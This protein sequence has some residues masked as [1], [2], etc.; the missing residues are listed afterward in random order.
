NFDG[1]IYYSPADFTGFVGDA[2]VTTEANPPDTTAGTLR[3]H[4]NPVTHLYETTVFDNTFGTTTN[5][6]ARFVEGDVSTPTPTPTATATGTATFTPT[7][8]ATATFTPTPTATA[9]FTPTPT[10]TGTPGVC[11]LT[12]GYWKN[13]PNAWPV[14]SLM[15]GSQSYTKAELLAILNTPSGG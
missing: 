4:F 3:V 8:T 9:T 14:N 2:I 11:P 6:G 10:P 12:Q 15:L 13:H 1:L 5:E 7:P